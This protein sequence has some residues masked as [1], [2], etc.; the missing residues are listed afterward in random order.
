[1]GLL[2]KRDIRQA[3]ITAH[4]WFD[5][6]WKENEVTRGQAYAWL[7]KQLGLSKSRCHIGEFDEDQCR[8]VVK[9]C[10]E[11]QIQRRRA[12]ADRMA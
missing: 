5:T 8:L 9:V 2:A 1:L 6:L 12:I 10:R 3:R 11:W 4:K 7:A